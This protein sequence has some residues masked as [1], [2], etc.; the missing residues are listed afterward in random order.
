[1]TNLTE[2][3]DCNIL[4]GYVQVH[5]TAKQY[6]HAH[7]QC[8]MLCLTFHELSMADWQTSEM[9]HYT[10]GTYNLKTKESN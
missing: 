5:E 4:L 2:T 8:F 3:D 7:I 9:D 6:A 10:N 1:M